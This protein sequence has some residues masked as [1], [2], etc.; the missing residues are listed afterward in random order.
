MSAPIPGDALAGRAALVTGASSGLGRHFAGVLAAAGARVA[1]A[2]RRID[3]LENTRAAIAASGGE[4]VVVSLDVCD[5]S[6]VRSA[7]GAT[8]DAFGALDILINN[9]GTTVTRP[10]L[11]L[12][13]Q[14]WDRVVDTNLKGCFL[15]AQEAA[16]AMVRLESGG[17]IVNVASILGLRV[18]SQL[19]PYIAS[20][21]ALVR[22][23]EAMALEFARYNI[24]V[25]ALCPGYIRTE[26]NDAFFAT[27]AGETVVKRIP[28]RR[29]GTL[30]DLDGPLLLLCSDAGAYMTGATLAVDGGHLVNSL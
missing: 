11:D 24:R 19:A 10:L 4:A 16:R 20:K 14:E 17:A 9:A 12:S 5:S 26:L 27:P 8:V 21:A 2:A 7:I 30:R 13:E 15:V 18:A 29:L 1:L 25:N 3:E 23:S 28:Q 22:L 6:S